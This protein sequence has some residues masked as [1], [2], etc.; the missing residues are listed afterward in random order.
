MACCNIPPPSVAPL[1]WTLHVSKFPRLFWS[2][3]LEQFHANRSYPLTSFTLYY[4]DLSPLPHSC[5]LFLLHREPPSPL[6][7]CNVFRWLGVVL[8]ICYDVWILLHVLAYSTS[9][10]L[11]SFW[12]SGPLWWCLL[13][14][15]SWEW[16]LPSL[17]SFIVTVTWHLP[18]FVNLSN[19]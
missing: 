17:F 13:P 9:A 12:Y 16:F 10:I 15:Y 6:F 14:Y 5:W 8:F 11:T 3:S 4:P 18:V 7:M 2:M 1:P 19:N